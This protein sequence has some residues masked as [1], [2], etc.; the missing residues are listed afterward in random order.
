MKHF[1]DRLS[2]SPIWQ[3]QRNYFANKGIAAWSEN[4]VPDFI[5]N[6]A[7][8]AKAFARVTR[9]YLYDY[10]ASCGPKGPETVYILE[11]GAGSGRFAYRFLQ[12]LHSGPAL[13]CPVT[14]VLS[15][16][17]ESLLEF[18]RSHPRLVPFLESGQLDFAHYDSAE[19]APIHLE[20]SGQILS[21]ES[22]Q[23]PLIVIGNYYFDSL[24]HD[25][26]RIEKGMLL[27]G[28]VQ[29]TTPEDEGR[30]GLDA[31]GQTLEF[32][33]LSGAAYPRADW[34]AIL[35]N[36]RQTLGEGTFTFPV[37]G[38]RSLEFL[39]SLSQSGCF[40]LAADKGPNLLPALRSGQHEQLDK[41]GAISAS[42]NFHALAQWLESQGKV[43]QQN[44]PYHRL[45]VLALQL[46]QNLPESSR[47][48]LAFQEQ[49]IAF[50]PDDYTNL[51]DSIFADLD[52]Q[53]SQGLYAFLRLSHWDPEILMSVYTR[54]ARVLP[55]CS[56]AVRTAF[57]AGFRESWQL[58]YALDQKVRYGFLLGSLCASIAAFSDALHFFIASLKA[59]GEKGDTVFNAALCLARLGANDESRTWLH[60]AES[61][62]VDP[63]ECDLVRA[64]LD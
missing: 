15:D 16:F 12:I 25:L 47:T 46:G 43:F 54:L 28:R 35:E 56:E 36:Y 13:P 18:W 27:E 22:L 26:F 9:A 37:G 19:N 59:E 4:V 5:T 45:N 40:M 53:S 55:T 57:V 32:V 52:Q 64:E 38:M 39:A 30:S 48:Q 8:T 11:A 51:K 42:V 50:G 34:N 33:P 62:G 41:H 6:N 61:L 31:V 49:I 17:T 10:V 44:H 7:F 1:G 60:K 20:H 58:H 29:F 2:E 24:P 3:W 21:P 63:E 14:F 23:S